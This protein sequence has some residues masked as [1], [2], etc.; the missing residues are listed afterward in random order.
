M[1][2]MISQ[3]W[4]GI[5]DYDISMRT[6]RAKAKLKDLGYDLIEPSGVLRYDSTNAAEFDF[7]LLSESLST[8]ALCDAVYFVPGWSTDRRCKVEHKIAEVYG[9]TC[10]F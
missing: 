9:L 1:Y 10:I 3:P 8:M 5:S 6:D 2:A 7:R 4:N